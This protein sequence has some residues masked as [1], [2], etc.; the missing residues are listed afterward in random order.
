[1]NDMSDSDPNSRALLRLLS[2]WTWLTIGILGLAVE[3]VI[4]FVY[5]TFVG[6]VT[7]AFV[8]LRVAQ[9]G[10]FAAAE[11]RDREVAPVREH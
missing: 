4:A 5:L 9:V 7:F 10:R 1:M 11:G 2:Y 6:I 3:G 8:L